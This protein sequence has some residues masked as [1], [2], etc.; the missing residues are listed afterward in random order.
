MMRTTTVAERELTRAPSPRDVF[1][2][3]RRCVLARDAN[4]FADLFAP[5]AVVEYP[6]G[7]RAV[8]LPPY[9]EGREQIRGHLT[10]A[11]RR[12]RAAG[13][14]M[15]A[16]DAVVVHETTDPEVIIV[17]FDLMGELSATGQTYQLPYVQVFRIRDGAIVTMR[18]YFSGKRLAEVMQLVE[19][20]RG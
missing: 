18:D 15:I 16:Y 2:R 6:F 4:G 1:E 19:P 3:A 7:A 8:G 10:A 20:P 9:L 11:M 13:G 12:S 17:E 14:R 5:D